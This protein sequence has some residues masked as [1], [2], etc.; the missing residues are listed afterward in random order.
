MNFNVLFSVFKRNFFGYLANPTGYVFITVFVLLSSVAAFLPDEFFNANLANL[1]QL[2]RWFPLIM[3]VFVPAITMGIWA[4][5]RRQGTDELLLTIPASDSDIVF[6]K[7]KGAAAIYTLSLLFSLVCSLAILSYLGKPD[8]GLFLCT[9]LGYWFVGVA[10]L[11]IGMTASFLTGNLTVAY[12]LGAIFCTPFIALQWSDSLPLPNEAVSVL[13]SFS[14]PAQFELFGRGIVN[15]SSILYFA[16]LTATMLYLSMVLIGKRHWSANQCFVGGFHYT[17]RTAALLAIGLSLV[18]IFRQHDARADLTAEHLS[19]LAPNTVKLLKELKPQHTVVVDA[20]ISPDV[21]ESHIQAKLD[22]ESILDEI[23]SICGKKVS[24]RKNYIR[25]NTEQALLANQRYEIKPHDVSFTSQGKRELKSIFLGVSFRSGLNT[26]TLPFID[27]GLSAEYELVHALVN[28]AA[29][30]NKRIGILKTDVPLTGG[31]DMQSMSANPDM[32]IVEELKKQYNVVEVNPAEPIKEKYDALLAV[33]PSAMDPQATENF[34]NAVKNGQPA[35]IFEDPLPVYIRGVA[36]TGEP[37]TP[38]NQMA[39]MM[40]RQ[41]PKG[42]ISPLWDFLG[43]AVDARVAVWQEYSPIRKI[44]QIPKGFVFLDRS[45]NPNRKEGAENETD[46][47]FN[48]KDNVSSA[49]QYMMLPFPGKIIVHE[50]DSANPA[51]TKTPLLQTFM[52]PA[53][54]VST[55]DVMRWFRSGEQGNAWVSSGDAQMLAV[56][57][58]GE[59]PVSPADLPGD[60]KEKSE[61]KHSA[62]NVKINVIL[63]SDI[64]CLSDM[65]F[66][67]RKMGNEP[68]AGIDLNFD[69]ATF[70]LNAVDSAAGDERFLTIRTRRPKHRTLSKFDENTDSIRRRAS[71]KRETLQKEFDTQIKKEEIEL[72]ETSKK[73]EA[74]LKK[75]SVNE[76]EALRKLAAAMMTA[77]KNLDSK[78]ESLQRELAIEVEKSDVSLNEQIQKIQG[79]YKLAA[80]A[81]PPLPPLLIGLAVFFVRKTR[82]RGSVP[83]SRRKK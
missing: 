63:I 27:R 82:E 49:L 48:Q 38:P 62:A 15:F 51:L 52:K 30:Q 16:M 9:Y 64:D 67:L 34:I 10:M 74:D 55:M 56:R 3:L 8:I 22:M 11:A 58:T 36:G 17:V 80:V 39:M 73:L 57:I 35:V 59:V 65:I 78:K 66:N 46:K 77:Q 20:F 81:L 83:Q 19:T 79:Q 41:Q 18:F 29:P 40:G 2:N 61:T 72:S 1:D 32:Q 12:I 33:Q 42:D 47:P 44:S 45:H 6:G 68:G 43:T 28:V 54:T 75:G 23:Q 13:K 60:E 25:P 4:D 21:P 50:R 5:E 37:R 76:E 31:F 24:V 7:F 70:V 14:I 53:G 71:E 69:N 26:L